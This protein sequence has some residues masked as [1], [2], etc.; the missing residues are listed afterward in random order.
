MQSC[1]RV[2]LGRPRPASRVFIAGAAGQVLEGRWAQ[3]QVVTADKWRRVIRDVVR[4][5]S[6]R[7]REASNG[8]WKRA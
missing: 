8:L 3:D 5:G 1:D 7:P 2:G 6:P 4:V